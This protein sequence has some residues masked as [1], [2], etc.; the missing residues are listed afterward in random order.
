MKEIVSVTPEQAIRIQT[1]DRAEHILKSAKN[2]FPL[3][4]ENG[5]ELRVD[6]DVIKIARGM[7]FGSYNELT[8]EGLGDVAK[9]IIEN[10]KP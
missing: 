9:Q 8:A 5:N 2:K 6:S 3:F 10:Y 4:T 1:L 7:A